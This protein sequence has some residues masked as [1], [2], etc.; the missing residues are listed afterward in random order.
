MREKP[1]HRIS[2][3]AREAPVLEAGNASFNL[4]RNNCSHIRGP[5]TNRDH[6]VRMAAS[7]LHELAKR[8]GPQ[9]YTSTLIQGIDHEQSSLPLM[10]SEPFQC[11]QSAPPS[12]PGDSDLAGYLSPHISVG[13]EV[14]AHQENRGAVVVETSPDKITEEVRLSLSCVTYEQEGS[15]VSHTRV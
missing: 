5:T 3:D 7:S 8:S 14:L 13:T 9:T 1:R 12:K 4:R 10:P 15:V 11:R 6:E 2:L